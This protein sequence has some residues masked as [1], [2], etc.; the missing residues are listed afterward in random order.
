MAFNEVEEF[1]DEYQRKRYARRKN[2]DVREY[3]K[4]GW[5]FNRSRWLKDREY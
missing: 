5:V 3:K 2:N 1:K 4:T